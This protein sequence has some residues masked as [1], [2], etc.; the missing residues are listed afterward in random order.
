MFIVLQGAQ[1]FEAVGLAD[2]VTDDAFILNAKCEINVKTNCTN[3]LITSEEIVCIHFSLE[4][5][6][7]KIFISVTNRLLTVCSFISGRGCFLTGGPYCEGPNR[8]MTFHPTSIFG[9]ILSCY[10]TLNFFYP[11]ATWL[12]LQFF[13]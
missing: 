5:L 13:V 11:D 4:M 2:E 6:N 9:S 10:P 8:F 3:R 12:E 1:I 7:V